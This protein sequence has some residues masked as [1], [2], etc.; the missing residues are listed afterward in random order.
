[1]DIETITDLAW[2]VDREIDMDIDLEQGEP[3]FV[4]GSSVC[5]FCIFYL[6]VPYY[7]FKRKF[8]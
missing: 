1:M 2:E 3:V 6:P 7:F 5:Q 8:L 4:E